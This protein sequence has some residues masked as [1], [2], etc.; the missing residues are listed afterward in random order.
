MKKADFGVLLI[1]GKQY[2][3]ACKFKQSIYCINMAKTKC[4]TAPRINK[5][6]LEEAL[7]WLCIVQMVYFTNRIR[8]YKKNLENKQVNVQGA[9]EMFD[10]FKNLKDAIY[11]YEEIKSE[12]SKMLTVILY[13]KLKLEIFRQSD[14]FGKIIKI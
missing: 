5:R 14:M 7:L 9:Q 10:V 8:I 6:D 2:F 12:N 13:I 3:H 1:M 11:D 4:K